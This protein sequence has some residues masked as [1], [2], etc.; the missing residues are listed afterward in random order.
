ML[1]EIF[2]ISLV[3]LGL[4]VFVFLGVLAIGIFIFLLPY[5][6]MFVLPFLVWVYLDD[7]LKKLG[8]ENLIEEVK[9]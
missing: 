3:T 4:F 5:L 8:L 1:D 7:I 2:V 6:A 9:V